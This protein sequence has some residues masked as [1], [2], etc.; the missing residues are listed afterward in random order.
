MLANTMEDWKPSGLCSLG[1]KRKK[2]EVNGNAHFGF[3]L[4]NV[5][6]LFQLHALMNSIHIWGRRPCANILAALQWL[7]EVTK[8]LAASNTD[9]WT[10]HGH[11]E[12]QDED[13]A[14]QPAKI[15]MYL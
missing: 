12:A 6:T 1:T 10:V 5:F 7:G 3:P 8:I 2:T 15:K 14:W 13:Q 9:Y 4:Q 11:H